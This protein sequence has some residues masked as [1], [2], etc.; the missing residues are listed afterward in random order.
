MKNYRIAKKE[1]I[2]KIDILIENS[3]FM[4]SNKYFKVKYYNKI[5]SVNFEMKTFLYKD[6]IQWKRED[7]GAKAILKWGNICNLQKI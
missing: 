1:D 3:K 4:N 2:Y 5:K 6:N 7:I